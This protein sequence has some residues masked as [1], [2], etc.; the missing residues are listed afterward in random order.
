MT[1]TP[2]Q[3][4]WLALAFRPLFLFAGLFSVAAMLWWC[5]FWAKPFAWQAYGGPLWWHG[6]E[7]I[8]GFAVAVVAGFLLTAVQT[9][10]G[11]RAIN[12]WPLAALISLWL[13]G[14]LLLAFGSSLPPGLIAFVDCCFLLAAALA[15]A[16]PVL[17]AKQW[18]NLIF[19]PLLII[20]GLLNGY[21]HWAV[22]NDQP[23]YASRA[24]QA[25]IL[26]ITVI[27]VVIGGRV[28]PM[29]TANG[30]KTPKALPIKTLEVISI[31]SL[32][33]IVIMLTFPETIPPR[34][35]SLIYG[36]AFASN[37]WRFLRWRFWLCW[38]VPLLWSLQLA[39]AFIPLGLFALLLHSLGWWPNLSSALHC[40]SA[41]AMGSMILS[42]M[43]RV[44]LGHTGRTLQVPTALSL[45]FIFILAAGLVRILLPIH[46]PAWL[47]YTVMGAGGLWIAAYTIFVVYYAPILCNPRIDGRP[48]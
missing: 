24:L 44:S 2:S 47:Q 19:V 13:A 20:L 21:S 1:Q 5:W 12:G 36:L 9:W 7:M 37:S 4:V 18:R 29:F 34:G 16:H 35:Q 22:L 45:A 23:L 42:M 43:A 30:T 14:R 17:V 46:N 38:R 8:F 28:I 3:P 41:G 33:V 48:G 39:Y 27:M 40:F 10:T 6:H 31:A 26:L 15:L 11:V 32:L 25:A